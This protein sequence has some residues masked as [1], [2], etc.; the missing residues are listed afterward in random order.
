MLLE[1]I[2][3]KFKICPYSLETI[4]THTLALTLSLACTPT[5]SRTWS[6]TFES[7]EVLVIFH[8]HH[9]DFIIFR[10]K[11]NTLDACTLWKGLCVPENCCVQCCVQLAKLIKDNIFFLLR[12]HP[13]LSCLK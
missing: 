13:V 5:Q 9:C 11:Q 2:L 6:L 7:R 4:C 10:P 8:C 1:I 3:L 12:G